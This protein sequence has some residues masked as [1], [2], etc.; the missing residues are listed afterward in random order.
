MQTRAVAHQSW[1]RRETRIRVVGSP[2][3]GR[4][5][6]DGIR[7]EGIV[8]YG[9]GG[10]IDPKLK[11]DGH[12]C[13]GREK[14]LEGGEASGIYLICWTVYIEAKDLPDGRGAIGRTAATKDITIPTTMRDLY[15]RSSGH[16]ATP[17]AIF[18]IQTRPENGFD[19][20]WSI[21]PWEQ[22]QAEAIPR[23]F[24]IILPTP[25]APFPPSP[26]SSG[27]AR[28]IVYASGRNQI[29]DG[30][31][32]VLLSNVRSAAPDLPLDPVVFRALLF[33]ILASGGKNLLLRSSDEDISLIQNIAALVSAGSCP[34][35]QQCTRTPR[36]NLVGRS[37]SVY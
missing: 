19:P 7:G 27:S 24:Q 28:K 37:G 18:P 31:Y 4:I 21:Q 34:H 25:P 29:T 36:I 1:G 13:V 15:I 35:P 20:V 6:G 33:C 14:S 11:G 26:M 10:I 3:R 5:A 22:F 23:A 30:F 2:S 8:G 17:D 9:G 32:T 16:Q 12:T